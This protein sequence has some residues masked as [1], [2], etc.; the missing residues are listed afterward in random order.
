MSEPLKNPRDLPE[1][2]WK[3]LAAE[4]ELAIAPLQP[5]HTAALKALREAPTADVGFIEASREGMAMLDKVMA[6]E[7]A[8]LSVVYARYGI[9]FMGLLKEA[10]AAEGLTLE[11][12]MAPHV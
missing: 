11:E 1:A 9:D 7:N 12:A 6:D 5:A 2:E 3:A 10:L 8:A 4:C